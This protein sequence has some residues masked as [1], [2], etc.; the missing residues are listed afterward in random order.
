[1]HLYFHITVFE[2]R[3]KKTAQILFPQFPLPDSVID[4]FV[5]V[6]RTCYI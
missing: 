1:L 2:Y 5:F 3:Q 4:E 6:K